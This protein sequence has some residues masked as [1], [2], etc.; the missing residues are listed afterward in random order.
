MVNKICPKCGIEKSIEK[1]SKNKRY[2]DGLN[3]WC[4]ECHTKYIKD[5]YKKNREQILIEAKIKRDK[6]DNKVKQQ[7]YM[8]TWRTD[9]NNLKRKRE[10]DLNLRKNLR[11]EVIYYCSYGTMECSQCGEKS[12]EL[13]EIHHLDYD[14]SIHRR[15]IGE[16]KIVRWAIENGFPENLG[17]L[18]V[19][20]NSKDVKI[21]SKIKSF[22]SVLN[23]RDYDRFYNL[24]YEVAEN[25]KINGIIQCE[26]CGETDFDILEL[27]HKNGDGA[28]HRKELGYTR[29]NIN[30]AAM[31]RYAKKHNYP[32][33]FRILCAGCNRSLGIRG[34]TP[35]EFEEDQ[36][37]M[38]KR[39]AE[40]SIRRIEHEYK[41]YKDNGIDINDLYSG[42][43]NS[44]IDKELINKRRGYYKNNKTELLKKNKI[45]RERN[46][47]KCNER[48]RKY[49][50]EHK[51]ERKIKNKLY[52]ER[53]KEEIKIRKK[54]YRERKKLEKLNN[55]V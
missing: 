10:A 13:L 27:D 35:Y 1:F 37:A 12:Y 16:S 19:K 22:L 31:Y 34:Y 48:S 23:K 6:P 38:R 42:H 8:K 53:K 52:Q 41:F 25:Y 5:Y 39:V 55:G 30:G 46:K 40:Q 2:D 21:R 14:G 7:E 36:E 15:E 32:N 51:E 3:Y 11:S 33:I 45:Y 17:I 50:E 9:P 26:Y 20:C 18:C 28:K 4:K 24:R 49:Y 29:D 44:E 43:N 47:E 54:E